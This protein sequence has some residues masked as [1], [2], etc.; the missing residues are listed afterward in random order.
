MSALHEFKNYFIQEFQLNDLASTEFK[1]S[2]SLKTVMDRKSKKVMNNHVITI[3]ANFYDKEHNELRKG[4]IKFVNNEITK[5]EASKLVNISPDEL[6]NR[7][8]SAKREI[9]SLIYEELVDKMNSF[10]DKINDLS[11]YENVNDNEVIKSEFKGVKVD[12]VGGEKK[13]NLYDM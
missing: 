2:H 13:S 6:T 8:N 11:S 10:N 4:S 7:F 5:K 3:N 12:L 1:F 9:V